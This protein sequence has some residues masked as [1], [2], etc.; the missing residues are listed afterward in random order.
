MGCLFTRL[1]VWLCY[2]SYGHGFIVS[3][4]SFYGRWRRWREIPSPLCFFLCLSMIYVLVFLFQ[5]FISILM[6][7]RFI[8]LEIGRIWMR[9]LL[10]S[11]RIWLWFLDGR[12]RM[13]C[14]LTPARRRQFWFRILL[15]AWCCLV[16]S[17]VRR[18]FHGVMVIEGVF[19]GLCHT[20]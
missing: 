11:M 2:F 13:G 12:L 9:W 10:H 6:I 17:W 16:C 15:W 4:R 19:E 8:G 20:A 18:R 14:K 5:S 1:T 3:S 7:C